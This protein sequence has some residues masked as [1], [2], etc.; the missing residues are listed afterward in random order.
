MI[1]NQ[2]YD[3]KSL[4]LFTKRNP[5]WKELAKDCV[6]FANAQGGR[7]WIGIDDEKD[8]PSPHQQ[9]DM[10]LLNRIQ[11]QILNRTV[12]V[13]I[14]TTLQV[15]ENGGEYIEVLVHRS[16]S[17]I[18][19]TTDGRYYLRVGEDCK[20][21][22]PDEMHRLLTD[23][24]AFVWELQTY[25][26][27]PRQEVEHEKMQ[28]F[29]QA[30]RASDRVSSFVKGKTD[31][32]LLEY[33]L[34]SDGTF[35]TNLGILWVGK[36]FHR[37][38]LLFAPAIQ[39]IKFDENGE[40]VNKLVWDDFTLN[41]KELIQA[42]WSQI[43]DWKEGIEIKDGIFRKRIANYDEV[44]VRELIANALVHRPYTMRGDIFI[45]LFPDRLEV[46]NPGPF[47][48][49][50]TENNI[51]HQSVQRN[52]HLAKVFYDLNLMEKEGSGYDLIFKTLLSAGKPIPEPKESPDRV[53]V[54]IRKRIVNQEIIN[55]IDK[56]NQEYQLNT[57]ELISLGLI[58]QHGTL[59]AIEM[60]KILGLQIDE[61][62]KN[63]FGRSL[64]FG[65]VRAKG[66]TKGTTY[67]ID[68]NLLK[69]LNFQ[70]KTTL[71]RIETHRLKELILEDLRIYGESSIGD[72]HRRIGKEIHLRS[73]RSQ[74]SNLI[75]EGQISK[76]GEKRGTKYLLTIFFKK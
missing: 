38:K 57:K 71:R 8:M 48:L 60:S 13:S 51:L 27:V 50:V 11:R 10:Q 4:R 28:T 64:E 55:F 12:N 43:P 2:H 3:K 41:P 49:G 32:E 31:E 22:P 73:I 1:E 74:I 75:T 18:A 46:H 53:S 40:K 61:A 45:N 58:A 9:I 42:V 7:I 29:A 16:A 66:K 15:A 47:P 63:W 72:I 6:S 24:G 76:K 5:D 69:K 37:A 14:N 17:A 21:V 34:F 20:P 67:F 59:T 26:K 19:S 56:A 23:K 25:Q 65:L 35:L 70:G 33:Y 30:I 44:I 62:I 36:R 52:P 54:T 39:F 68:P